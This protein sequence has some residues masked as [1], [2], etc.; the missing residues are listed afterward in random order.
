MVE[1]ADT[2]DAAI[3]LDGDGVRRDA[4]LR[5]QADRIVAVE[6]AP[7]RAPA[8]LV[9]PALADA[10]DHGRALSTFAFGAADQALELWIPGVFLNPALPVELVASVALARLARAGY[11]S[12]AHFHGPQSYDHLADEAAAVAR[13]AAAVGV[14]L[15]FIVPLR[16]RN[17]LGYGDDD[18]ILARVPAEHRDALRATWLFPLPPIE[19]QLALVDEIAARCA[20]EMVDV[21]YGPIGPQWCS[22]RLLADIA[23]AAARTGRRIHTH[24]FETRYQREWADAVYPD[25]LLTRLDACGFL[26]ARL[27]VA[28][29]VWLRP[30]DC[31]LLAARG[32]TVS[33][34][35]SSNLRL[36]SGL[37]PAAALHQAGV[38][39]ALG[40]DAMPFGDV[41]DGL[42][43]L[44]L[45]AALHGGT[46]L[47]RTITDAELLRAATVAGQRATTRCDDLGAL[48]PGAPADF[49]AL[50]WAALAGDL[51][52]DDLVDPLAIVIA[53]GAARHIERLVVAGR[54]VVECGRVVGVDLAALE[55]ELASRAA[56]A[57]TELA[58]LRPLVRAYQAAL[59]DF[60]GSGQHRRGARAT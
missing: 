10:H 7:G 6:P 15:A 20:N 30:D 27:T 28:H 56:A 49:L 5:W 9:M 12:I 47:E 14:R 31:A 3:L 4:R 33:L 22:D 16:D 2:L 52:A 39:L 48:R 55:T 21:Q 23:A 29:G 19:A 50:D 45:A 41:E 60:Y 53:R 42:Q 46:G 36:R 38:R 58:A 13:A 44:R 40:S 54:T 59:R 8:R 51:L 18:A 57:G 37:A 1:P 25:G 43:E 17:R 11:G 34:N 26:C 24:L 35:T 32:V